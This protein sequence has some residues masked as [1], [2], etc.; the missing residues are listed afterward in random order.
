MLLQTAGPQGTRRIENE[1]GRFTLIFLAAD[2]GHHGDGKPGQAEVELT[3]NWQP[4]DGGPAETY[5]GGRNFGHLAYRVEDIYE[6]CARLQTGG[7]M[8]IWRLSARQTVSRTNCSSRSFGIQ[9]HGA[10]VFTM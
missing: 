10:P 8:D 3:Y 7:V 2:E 1:K 9:R 4:E 6:T 5:T